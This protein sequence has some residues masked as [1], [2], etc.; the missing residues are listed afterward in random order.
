MARLGWGDAV[1]V[2]VRL[3]DEG[4]KQVPLDPFYGVRPGRDGL[5]VGQIGAAVPRQGHHERRAERFGQVALRLV[6]QLGDERRQWSVDAGWFVVEKDGVYLIRLERLQ[7]EDQGLMEHIADVRP[8][9]VRDPA[10][11]HD[12]PAAQL[13]LDCLQRT[14]GLAH[15]VQA[16][17]DR[18]DVPTGQDRSDSTVV[19]GLA[20]DR[21]D[22][23]KLARHP[24]VQGGLPIPGSKLKEHGQV[25]G[26]LGEVRDEQDARRGLAPA[27]CSSQ[28]QA[29]QRALVGLVPNAVDQLIERA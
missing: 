12:R 1:V 24:R 28:D 9:E 25:I 16:V 3:A 22:L 14:G 19:L 17:Q 5:E 13:F 4:A 18:Q 8:L 26:S 20:E 15:L 29:R 6:L 10:G 2:R 21:K 23:R 27:H 11:Q 7:F